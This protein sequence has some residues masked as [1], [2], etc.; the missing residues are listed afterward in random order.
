MLLLATGCA[1]SPP[2]PARATALDGA[3]GPD[4]SVSRLTEH[5][6]RHVSAAEVATYGRVEANGLIIV[7]R[8]GAVVVDT[9]WTPAQTEWLINRV[10]AATGRAPVAM[11]ATH[12][13]DDRAGGVVVARAAGIPVYAT[14]RTRELLGTAGAAIDHPFDTEA[15]IDLGDIRIELY[16]PGPGHTRDNSVVY[17]ARDRLLFG[18]CLV[19]ADTTDWIGNTSDADVDAWP[20]TIDRLIARYGGRVDVVV[21]GHGRPGDASLLPHTR[22]LAAGAARDA[23]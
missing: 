14:R 17:V 12:F 11:V 6:W 4:I 3:S 2:A 23:R 10:R 22:Q 9:A 1:G 20:A 8:R 18:G 19:R 7:G 16:Y 15:T 5:V 21:P 13:H